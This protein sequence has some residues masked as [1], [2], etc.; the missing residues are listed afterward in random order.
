MKGSYIMT[1]ICNACGALS[2]VMW[3]AMWM[4]ESVQ[5]DSAQWRDRHPHKLSQWLFFSWRCLLLGDD[6]EDSRGV[7]TFKWIL[8]EPDDFIWW[9]QGR[10]KGDTSQVGGPECANEKVQ[11]L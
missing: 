6:K 9:Y 8:E 10:G 5:Q 1:M 3:P 7:E 11:N 2:R 4:E